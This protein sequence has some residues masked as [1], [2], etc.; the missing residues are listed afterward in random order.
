MS[1]KTSLP[2]LSNNTRSYLSGE[3]F[4]NDKLGRKQLAEKLT[5]YLNRLNDGAVLA[6]DAPWGEGKT[7]FGKNWNGSL[8]KQSYKTVFIDAFEQDYIEDPFMLITSEILNTTK[9]CDPKF[10]ELKKSGVEVA[11]TL[12]PIGAKALLNFGGRVLLGTHEFSNIAEEAINAGKDITSQLTSEWLDSKLDNYTTDKVAIESFKQ[13]LKEYV[14]KQDKPIIIFIDELDRC[15]PTFAVNLIERI[16]HIFDI[17][18]IIFILLLNREQLESA[19]K[20]VYGQ[21]TDAN[22]Y[23]DKFINF[24]FKFPI[25]GENT[26]AR[27]QQL[28]NFIS[29]TMSKYD[30]KKMKIMTTL[31]LG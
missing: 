22:K 13:Q 5:S 30:L 27:D 4:E 16:K 14:K 7:W 8:K 15:K 11:K 9:S 29:L 31:N 21:D 26:H 24:Y 12:L 23:L 25:S 28:E 20:G 2:K 19:V 10:E 6:I 1:T 17:Q 3:P 18:N